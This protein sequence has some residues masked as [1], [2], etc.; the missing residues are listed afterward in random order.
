MSHPIRA[1]VRLTTIWGFDRMD[2]VETAKLGVVGIAIFLCPGYALLVILKPQH[3]FDIVEMLCAAGGLSI[4]AVP[5]VLYASTYL[6]LQLTAGRTIGFLLV[7]GGVCLWDWWRRFSGWR[8]RMHQRIDPVN[9]LLGVVFLM[10]LG[11]RIWMVRDI[12]YPLWTDSYHHTIITQL[13]IDMGKVPSSYEPYAPI[14]QF[15]YHFGFHALSAWVHWLSG[16]PVPRSVVLVGQIINALAVPSCYLLTLRLFRSRSAGLVSALVVGLVSQMPTLFVNWGRYSQLSGQTL[17]PVLMILTI[18]AFDPRA[19]PVYDWILG[20]IGAAGLF[21]VHIRI[22]LFYGL[23][24]GLLL[25]FKLA[26]ALHRRKPDQVKYL[27]TGGVTMAGVALIV[28]APWLWRFYKGFGSTVIHELVQGYQPQRDSSYFAWR[29]QD[30]IDFGMQGYLLILAAMGGLWGIFKRESN[31]YLM[32]IWLASMF[33]AANCYLVGLTPL[34]SN[35]TVIILIYLFGAV[36]IGYLAGELIRL[37]MAC[38]SNRRWIS[39]IPRWCA[40]TGF[41]LATAVGVRYT[42]RLVEPQNGFVRP[43]DLDAMQWIQKNVPQEALFHISTRFWTPLV[44]HGLDAGYWLPFLATRQ[45]T[46]PPETY[47]SDGSAEYMSSINQRAHEL[48]E[49]GTPGQLW[50]V[51]VKYGV[52]HIYIGRRPTYLRPEFFLTDP[53]HF[54]TLYSEDGVWIFEVVG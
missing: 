1:L 35:V 33:I 3:A 24:A 14:D 34:V 48:L 18:D 22:F 46:I 43:A 13:I 45:T 37:S 19:A 49:A 6:G 20:G 38:A 52:T 16:S 29:A 10:S 7:A 2:L 17:L 9:L 40:S 5:L 30:V 39:H 47:A 4:A 42:V 50:R 23:F 31:I 26:R 44:A 53:A 21:L 25:L 51:A 27:F 41:V 12:A 36:M 8:N 32:V 11:A 28:T 54:N 15:T